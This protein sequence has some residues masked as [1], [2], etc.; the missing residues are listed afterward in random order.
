LREAECN[1]AHMQCAFL[2]A[3]GRISILQKPSN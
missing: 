3:D 2:E 1:I